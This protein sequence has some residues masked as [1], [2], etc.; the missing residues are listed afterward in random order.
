VGERLEC[1]LVAATSRLSNG[2]LNMQR[3][4]SLDYAESLGAG[5]W[6]AWFGSP[7]RRI[8]YSGRP[9][10]GSTTTCE[11]NNAVNALTDIV[12]F[13]VIDAWSFALVTKSDAYFSLI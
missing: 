9:V 8:V 7:V 11:P 12:K 1:D 10:V 6:R 3:A 5:L 13:A 4:E 2:R